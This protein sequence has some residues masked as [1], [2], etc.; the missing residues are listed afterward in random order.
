MMEIRL[1]IRSPEV[2]IK[3]IL[4]ISRCPIKFLDCMPWGDSGGRGLLKLEGSKED[5]K[6]TMTMI[7]AHPDV[8]KVVASTLKDGG[9]VVTVTVRSCHACR[10]LS[11]SECFLLS[12]T[13]TDEG[14]L[15]WTI[16]A[17]ND[18]SVIALVDEL[19]EKGTSVRFVSISPI[20]HQDVLTTRQLAT[21]KKAYREG[22]Y[23]VPK[24]T[25]IKKLAKQSGA[26][27]STV[28]EIL[29]RAEKKILSLFFK[30]HQ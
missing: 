18:K 6:A 16:I 22:Y 28:S 21:I 26:S 5:I 10:A 19:E 23:D 8:E 20:D 7:E 11:S 25:N 30:A 9:V 1:L 13:S 4:K 15:L 2:W 17:P 3:D 29:Q 12:S 27:P 24:R 14:D